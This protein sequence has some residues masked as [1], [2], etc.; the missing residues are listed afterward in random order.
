MAEFWKRPK[1]W[2]SAVLILWLFYVIYSNF[3]L[4]PVEIR[5][6]PKLVILQL[7]V[8]AVIIASAIFGS[9][10]TLVLQYYWRRRASNSGSRSTAASPSSSSTVA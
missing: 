8:S 7:R 2:I 4:D 9:A 1:F 10:L 6:V 3:Q 5:L